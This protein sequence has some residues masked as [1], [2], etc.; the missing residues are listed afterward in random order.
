MRITEK[1][2]SLKL[3]LPFLPKVTAISRALPF[4]LVS[5]QS[6]IRKFKCN[7][8]FELAEALNIDVM[9]RADFKR[10]KG[11]FK[12]ILNDS[13]IFINANLSDEMKRLV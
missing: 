8:P 2:G 1:L 12:V 13:F 3:T 11:A 4:L 5:P 9:E 7:D 10:Q 6:L